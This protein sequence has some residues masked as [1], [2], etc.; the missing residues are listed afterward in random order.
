MAANYRGRSGAPEVISDSVPLATSY[1][2]TETI[3]FPDR[4][5]QRS[6]PPQQSFA[7]IPVVKITAKAASIE[8]QGTTYQVSHDIAEWFRAMIEAKG[9]PI[10][11]SR[12]VRKAVD[13]LERL[14][15]EVPALR[16]L[17]VRADG[18]RGYR[19][20]VFD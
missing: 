3:G 11:A 6:V 13:T 20:S 4:T 19:M 16:Q 15:R 7:A 14:G 1:H 2:L 9:Q 10:G 12:Y 18:N 8:W 5:G 17:I